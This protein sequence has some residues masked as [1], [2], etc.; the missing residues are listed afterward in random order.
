[1]A[2]KSDAGE[3]TLRQAVIDACAGGTISFGEAARGK[4]F[5][6][7]GPIA[8]NKNLTIAGPGADALTLRSA[9][10]SGPQ[11]NV[12][13]VNFGVTAV[14]S[15]LTLSDG[16][17][18]VGGG[19]R[20]EGNLTVR[21]VVLSNN[22]GITEGGAIW[23]SGTLTL[24]K[25][26]LTGN[27][28]PIYYAEDRLVFVTYGGGIYSRFD[29]SLTITDSTVSGNN[30]N[31]GGGIY[32]T[33]A[34]ITN[35]T[36]GDNRVVN[37]VVHGDGLGGGLFLDSDGMATLTNCTVSQ[38]IVSAA[39]DFKSEGGGIYN[40]GGTLSLINTTVANNEI[41][42]GVLNNIYGAGISMVF[43]GAIGTVNARNSIIAG[44]KIFFSTSNG[45]GTSS[46][47]RQFYG[48]LTSQGYNLIGSI[49]GQIIGDTT[50][51]I[52]GVDPR[53]S[54]L[55]SYGGPTQTQ[56]LLTG[57]PAINAGNT[58]TSPTTDQR[59]A[60]RVGTADIGA[61][62]L[63]NSSNGGTLVTQLPDGFVQT[64]YSYTVADYSVSDGR[65]GSND[66]TYK[67]SY[68]VTSSALPNGISLLTAFNGSGFSERENVKFSGSPTQTGIFNF[69]VN[70]DQSANGIFVCHRLHVDD[71]RAE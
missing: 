23:N 13:L 22:R 58:A 33:S 18:D 30:S 61:F 46:T 15:G 35:T 17:A 57:S 34:A 47:A 53:L 32:A 42:N 41:V 39:N 54:P 71:P 50:G 6:T 25:S 56:A 2:N 36:I 64:P 21:N 5:L 52:V 12:V 70:G 28:K 29:A 24:D 8:I 45:S 48:T 40:N 9:V 49:N 62:E 16:F 3:G 60:A 59:D 27:G 67:Y 43:A 44:N 31:Q 26:R 66:D 51:N 14:I 68:T 19:I 65:G 20:N 11:N 10:R 55:G 69:S 38:N 7:G 4:I 63:N 37:G 1:M